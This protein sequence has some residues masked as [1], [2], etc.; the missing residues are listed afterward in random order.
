MDDVKTAGCLTNNAFGRSL[1][2]RS[3]TTGISSMASCSNRRQ[4]EIAM[5]STVDK[6]SPISQVA[7]GDLWTQAIGFQS[8]HE[9][10]RFL[11]LQ[12]S[13]LPAMK[14]TL[15]RHGV[16]HRSVNRPRTQSD[17]SSALK[18]CFPPIVC[19]FTDRDRHVRSKVGQC[20]LACDSYAGKCEGRFL[21]RYRVHA[22]ARGKL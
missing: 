16:R 9:C 4:R 14:S 15:H 11:R 3:T 17:I 1:N 2:A 10:T 7:Q 19:E 5:L 12:A 22:L 20:T 13:P 18:R 6:P 8:K 21:A